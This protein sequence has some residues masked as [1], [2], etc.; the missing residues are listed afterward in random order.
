MQGHVCWI[1]APEAGEGAVKRFPPAAISEEEILVSCVCLVNGTGC[2]LP[3]VVSLAPRLLMIHRPPSG[4]GV[5]VASYACIRPA[6]WD[7][8]TQQKKPHQQRSGPSAH[9][10]QPRRGSSDPISTP[11]KFILRA[12]P[13][14]CCLLRCWARDDFPFQRCPNPGSLPPSS[15]HL[16]GRSS[17]GPGRW[18]RCIART[19]R[20]D[21]S[22]IP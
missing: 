1:A 18:V 13:A 16:P 7:S 12:L 15:A 14:A 6:A 19:H 10:S 17:G 11:L 20:W 2:R 4:G 5:E 9:P 22:V 21:E 3:P 8:A